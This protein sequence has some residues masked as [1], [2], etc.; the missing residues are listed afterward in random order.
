M[1]L[2]TISKNHIEYHKIM[3][4]L[5]LFS[6][7]LFIALFSCSDDDAPVTV[8][9]N[10]THVQEA[11]GVMEKMGN[12]GNFTSALKNSA[13]GLNIPDETLTVLAVKDGSAASSDYTSD[14]LKRHIIKGAKDIGNFSGDTLELRSI[15]DDVLY[16]TKDNGQVLINDVSLTSTN[17]TKAGDSYIYILNS[18]VPQKNE[19]PKVPT[20]LRDGITVI[21]SDSL[22]F[23]LYAPGK[24]T[25][26]LIG[27]FNNWEVSND[28]R[29]I[30][31]GDRFYIKI[32]NLEKGKEYICQYL[33]DNT[34]KIADPYASKISD[35][36]N[37]DKIPSTI[38]PDLISYPRGKTTEIAMVVNTS[39]D[40]YSWKVSNFKLDNPDN[41]VIY[42]ILI[43][44]FTEQGSIKAVQEKLPYLKS[45]GVNA[46][47]LMPFNEFEGNE[48]WG[49]NP[50]F[51]FATDKAYGTANDY[52]AFIDACHLN[53]MAVIMDMVL[54]HSYGQSPMVRMY[55]DAS[56]NPSADNPWYN[57]KS[58]FANPDA[59]WGYDF[60][61]DSPQTRAFVDSVCA[62][63]MKE[64]KIDGFRFDFT[65][66]FS[67]TPYPAS[68]N[69]TWGNPYDA[70]R[71]SNLKR[72]YDEIQKR[73]PGAILILEHLSDN[74]EEKEL[75]DY[76]MMLWGNING[77]FNE[78]TMGYGAESGGYGPKGDVSWASYKERAWSKPNLVAYM[79]S[80]DEERIMFKNIAYGKVDGSYNVKNLETGLAR[81]EAAAVILM[82]LPGPKMIWQF[83]ELGYDYELNDD[84]L[85]HKPPRW[86]YYDVPE[87]KSLYDVYAKMNKLRNSNATFSSRDYTI[88]LR[89]QYKQVL[90][91]STGGYVCAIANFDVVPLSASVNFTKSGVWEDYF[92]N[93][94]LNVLGENMTIELQP[95]EYRLYMSK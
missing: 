68:G 77:N 39:A 3:E 62:F 84:R 25:V 9:E 18:I 4:F 55:R 35:P 63:W 5:R 59:Q 40:A 86:D 74:D 90:L 60:N 48:S 72:I 12:I 81:T 89:N 50:S 34:I 14:V 49:Y 24:K 11:I 27:D 15:S 30:K 75:A 79:E 61:H 23:V 36:W 28:Y 46:I 58:N 71:I 69:D 66:G 42:E 33:I 85:A 13:S 67:N 87:R 2:K 10:G 93:S 73:N 78:A 8:P 37:D 57:Q 95:G 64:Y 17:P 65:K 20:Y 88:D 56:G 31:S 1:L 16:V 94:T 26:H 54:N 29:M 83:G 53:G 43:R 7:V 51:F 52:K 32:G 41:M 45:L 38:Y 6:I 70:A 91:K 44:D 22:G 76:G 82:T 47:E 80:H 19:L 92:T 21:S